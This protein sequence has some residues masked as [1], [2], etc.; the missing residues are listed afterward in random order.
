MDEQTLNRR[1][2]LT[3]AE[4]PIKPSIT[5]RLK[6]CI[7][8]FYLVFLIS[9]IVASALYDTMV[10]VLDTFDLTLFRMGLFGTAHRYWGGLLM[11]Y[12][13]ETW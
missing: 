10:T 13:D 5:F 9:F 4:G 7:P 3:T 1:T 2:F 11:S 12:N 6:D 8:N